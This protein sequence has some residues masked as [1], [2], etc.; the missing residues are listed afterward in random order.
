LS[1]ALVPWLG[2]L[3]G[4]SAAL[5]AL[6]EIRHG[7][8]WYA[9]APD[10]RTRELAA[11]RFE[12]GV[13]GKGGASDADKAPIRALHPGFEWFVYNS[14]SDNYVPP[15]RGADEDALLVRLGAQR[16]IDPEAF[17]LHYYDDTRLVMRGDTLFIPGWGGGSARRPADA[18]IPVYDSGLTRRATS[19]A[20]P[21]AAQVAKEAVVSLAFDTPFTGTDLYPDGIFLDNSAA[22]LFN[23]GDILSGGTV[24]EAEGHAVLGSRRFSAWYWSRDLAPF[25]T[26]LRETLETSVTW[27]RDH[28]RKRLMINVANVWEDDYVTRRVADVL[29]LES[30][31]NPVRNAG[32]DAVRESRRRDASAAAKGMVTFYAASTGTRSVSGHEG[33]LSYGETL[34]GNLAWFLVSRSEGSILAQ[35]GTNDPSAAGWDTLTWRGCMDVAD[36]QL[37]EATGEPFTLARGK[38]PLG[39]SY[40]VEARAYERGLAVV[41]PRGS[42]REGIEPAGAVTVPLP[43]P[44]APVDPSGR[45]GTPVSTVSLRNGQGA[46]LLGDPRP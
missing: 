29:F 27:T 13:T 32:L 4:L 16:G 42:W 20:D 14:I 2:I 21:A 41:R 12:I 18:R 10:P 37:G 43:A 9:A 33:S 38:D 28:R 8:V 46:L 30:Q 25:L 19:F 7:V 22:R 3:I 39:R 35:M 26:A 6:G 45:I 24:R 36:A 1:R 17:Y 31:Y 11:R 34:L 40:V 44:L 5:P 23:F 15:A